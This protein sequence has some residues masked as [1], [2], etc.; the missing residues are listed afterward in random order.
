MKDMFEK[1]RILF[2]FDNSK[3]LRSRNFDRHD[4]HN[5]IILILISLNRLITSN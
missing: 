2:L 1:H 5:K 3:Y 4:L